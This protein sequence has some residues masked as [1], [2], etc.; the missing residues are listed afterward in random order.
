MW[1]VGVQIAFAGSY[2]TQKTPEYI[3][4][5]LEQ[6]SHLKADNL[7]EFLTQWSSNE[8]TLIERAERLF[9]TLYE[10][11]Y[12]EMFDVRLVQ[13]WLQELFQIGYIFPEILR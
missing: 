13:I 1:D 9:I 6:I 5:Q 12:I 8:T 10:H 11:G 7:T 3:P 2:V 4:E